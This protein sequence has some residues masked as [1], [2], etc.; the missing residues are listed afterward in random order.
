MWIDCSFL[1]ELFC[2]SF[3]LEEFCW[4]N[5]LK[6]DEETKAQRVPV[7]CSKPPSGWQGQGWPP[8]YLTDLR[9]KVLERTVLHLLVPWLCTYSWSKARSTRQGDVLWGNTQGVRRPEVQSSSSVTLLQLLAQEHIAPAKSHPSTHIILGNHNALGPLHSTCLQYPSCW[10]LWSHQTLQ[11]SCGTRYVLA[12][13]QP[14]TWCSANL[15]H[16]PFL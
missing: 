15:E 10:L 5:L 14:C 16:L 9:Q 7:I 1:R 11:S 12:S 13:S 8:S 3:E 2:G 4:F 6:S